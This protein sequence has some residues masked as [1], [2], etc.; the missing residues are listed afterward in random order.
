MIHIKHGPE[1]HKIEEGG[2]FHRTCS[3]NFCDDLLVEADIIY[4]FRGI[5][6][7]NTKRLQFY[8][9]KK[10]ERRGTVQQVFYSYML[11]F[12]NLMD[13]L[14]P[15]GS[16]KNP[17]CDGSIVIFYGCWIKIIFYAN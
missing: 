5:I 12:F 13:W 11:P 15:F 6:L 8:L 10:Q 1:M 17:R 2:K 3:A 7:C 9:N 4:H 16:Q 14:V